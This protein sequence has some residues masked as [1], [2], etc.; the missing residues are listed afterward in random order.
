MMDNAI[1][2]VVENVWTTYDTNGSGVLEKEE[3]MKFV[4]DSLTQMNSGR[5]AYE[6]KDS[7]FGA[8]FDELDK[9]HSGSIDK[10]EMFTFISKVISGQDVLTAKPKVEEVKIEKKETL[11]PE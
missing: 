9:D 3:A 1:Q 11:T 6:Y 4:K 10:G 2:Q 7:D 8:F 5:S